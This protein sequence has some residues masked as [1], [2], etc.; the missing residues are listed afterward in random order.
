M[1]APYRSRGE[2]GGEENIERSH[3]NREVGY[4]AMIIFAGVILTILLA[5]IVTIVS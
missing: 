2:G 1:L 5:I 3:D 4:S